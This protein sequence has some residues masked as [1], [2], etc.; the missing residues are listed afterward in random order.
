MRKF[1]FNIAFAIGMSLATTIYVEAN[2]SLPELRLDAARAPE[3]NL[4][5]DQNRVWADFLV[6][7]I[8]TMGVMGILEDVIVKDCY[9]NAVALYSAHG[10]GRN[11]RQVIPLLMIASQNYPEANLL[12]GY[13]YFGGDGVPQNYSTSA[14]YFK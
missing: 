14:T 5:P 8:E 12:L 4:P 6:T 9:Q 7:A 10:P 2:A 1:G 3:G 11:M 13:C